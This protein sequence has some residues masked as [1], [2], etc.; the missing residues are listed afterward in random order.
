MATNSGRG[1]PIGAADGPKVEMQP[2]PVSQELK[3]DLRN[4]EPTG[5]ARTHE[6]GQ[7]A[8]AIPP[9]ARVETKSEVE[10]EKA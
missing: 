9:G 2:P 5:S 3:E 8:E 6:P 4:T 10:R 1:N 7:D